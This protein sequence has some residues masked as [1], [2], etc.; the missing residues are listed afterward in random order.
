MAVVGKGI[1]GL[2]RWWGIGGYCTCPCK[3]ARGG[4]GC[5]SDTTQESATSPQRGPRAAN[6]ESRRSSSPRK[7]RQSPLAALGG[8]VGGAIGPGGAL[9]GENGLFS[10]IGS[11]KIAQ[12]GA[13]ALRGASAS[14]ATQGI[15]AA[16][17]LQDSFSWA[18]VAAAGIA[19]GVGDWLGGGLQPLAGANLSH[20]NIAAHTAVGAA[21]LIAS[22]ATRSAIEGSSFG[23][24]VMAGLPDVIGQVLGRAL[25]GVA[26]GMSEE[27]RTFRDEVE[28]V[29]GWEGANNQPL[30]VLE[31]AARRSLAQQQLA[32]MY[33]DP[34][35]RAL[36]IHTDPEQQANILAMSQTSVDNTLRANGHAGL[37]SVGD[38]QSAAIAQARIVGGERLETLTRKALAIA[39]VDD[40]ITPFRDDTRR[41]SLGSVTID[42]ANKY[43]GPVGEAAAWVSDTIDQYPWAKYALTALEF[44]TG[45]ASF[46]ASR[47]IANSPVGQFVESNLGRA[48]GWLNRQGLTTPAIVGGITLGGAVFGASKALSF[49][50]IADR[51]LGFR[52]ALAL[53]NMEPI[54]P[55]RSREPSTFH[56]AERVPVSGFS[57]RGVN[58][59]PGTRVIPEGIPEGWRIRGTRGDGGVQYYNPGNPNENVRVMQGDPLSPYPNSQAP[60]ARQQNAAETYLRQDGTPSPLPRG[61][62]YDPDAHIP[63][64]QFKVR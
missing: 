35:G 24:N 54:A 14:L 52:S 38:G 2:G 59:A 53:R 48:I 39:Y 6:R 32:N 51:T 34:T 62:R 30:S 44:V 29:R 57:P 43:L 12:I 13:G 8:E 20:G 37:E 25:A 60:Y 11:S 4:H 45:P 47:I 23:R 27:E 58:P 19:A 41:G 40:V 26:T 55:G 50:K 9:G 36:D 3:P 15:A 17:G 64:D 7:H 28:R 22:A 16:S 56:A 61:G 42:L 49:F 18:G 1:C 21:S 46:I 33:G 31:D 10:G 63:L 5:P